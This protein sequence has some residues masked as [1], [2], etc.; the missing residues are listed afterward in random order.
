MDDNQKIDFTVIPGE[1]GW[2]FTFDGDVESGPYETKMAAHA[3]AMKV[4]EQSIA[5]ALTSALF[6]ESA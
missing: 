3:G 5:E 2:Y 1:D 6:G 4:I